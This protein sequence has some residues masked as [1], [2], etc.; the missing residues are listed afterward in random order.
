MLDVWQTPIEFGHAMAGI[1]MKFKVGNKAIAIAG[2]FALAT[3]VACGGGQA[4][5]EP[6]AASEASS[7]ASSSADASQ[8]ESASSEVQPAAPSKADFAVEGDGW[9]FVYPEYWKGKI[10]CEADKNTLP[11]D[12]TAKSWIIT[13]A[14][15][16]N[17]QLLG[18][19]DASQEYIE[20]Y[21]AG[22]EGKAI[23]TLGHTTLGS[24]QTAT[25]MKENEILGLYA[26][27]PNGRYVIMAGNSVIPSSPSESQKKE[28]AVT[29][30]L[31]SFGKKSSWEEY[32]EAL[33]K[34]FLEQIAGY[35]YATSN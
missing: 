20:Q 7:V 35:V 24:G 26:Q 14:T 21:L 13:S 11:K 34:S 2:A 16:S 17:C 28:L 27:L 22:E 30:D 1:A 19:G 33:V 6:Q 15:D 4:A 18:I 5:P 32:D 23:K 3:L 8:G 10:D 31:Q 25:I 12:K 9:G 29:C